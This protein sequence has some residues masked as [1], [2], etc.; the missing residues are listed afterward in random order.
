MHRRR[1]KSL[2]P[3]SF[4]S[5]LDGALRAAPTDDEKVAVLVAIDGGPKQ[6]LLT[7]RELATSHSCRVLM[8]AGD[9]CDFAFFVVREPSDREH[10]TGL[11][12]YRPRRR[13]HPRVPLVGALSLLDRREVQLGS[14]PLF[15]QLRTR[16]RLNPRREVRVREDDHHRPEAVSY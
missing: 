3:R 6:R 13:T 2:R 5:F 16:E 12:R 7:D 1:A 9:V 14:E 8:N 11:P 10:S 4:N 15:F